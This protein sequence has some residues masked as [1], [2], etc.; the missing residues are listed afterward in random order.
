MLIITNLNNPINIRAT[1]NGL[2]IYLDNHS[3][4]QLAGRDEALRRRFIETIK[5]GGDLLFSVSNAAEIC[6]SQGDSAKRIIT[7]LDEIGG[8]WFPVELD[9]YEVSQREL[10]ENKSGGEA[11]VSR[12]FLRN[13]LALRGVNRLSDPPDDLFRLGLIF[14]GWLHPQRQSIA[15]GLGKLDQALIG[16]IQGYRQQA[17]SDANWLDRSFP[18]LQFDPAKPATFTYVNMVR[19]LV[20]ERGFQLKRGDGI[21]FCH[22]VIGASYASCMTLDTHWKRRIESLPK[23]HKLARIYDPNELDMMVNDLERHVAAVRRDHH[24]KL[25]VKAFQFF[26]ERGSEHGRDWEDWFNAEDEL[27]KL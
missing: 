22:A 18:V 27:G 7:F 23:P 6:R 8:H 17:S 14:N 5:L 21:D 4:I 25:Q 3:Y 2:P 24:K 11:F 12:S 15:E 26:E 20:D 16:R 13:V 19:H 10:R 9:P 1:V